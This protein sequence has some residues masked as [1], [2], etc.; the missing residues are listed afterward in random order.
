MVEWT[1]FWP[2]LRDLELAGKAG[3]NLQIRGALSHPEIQGKIRLAGRVTGAGH[4]WRFD[5]SW[6]AGDCSLM[7]AGFTIDSL[8]FG[9]WRQVP[10]RG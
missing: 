8:E 4:R 5:D 9:A 3:V 2:V 6:L 1:S 7:T 10:G